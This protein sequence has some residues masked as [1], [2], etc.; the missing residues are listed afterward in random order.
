MCGIVEAQ[1]WS[2]V[3]AVEYWS[4]RGQF[5]GHYQGQ[6]MW[7]GRCSHYPLT[8]RSIPGAHTAHRHQPQRHHLRSSVAPA[9]AYSLH[10]RLNSR[11]P[12]L[13]DASH[14][15]GIALQWAAFVVN[16]QTS[17]RHGKQRQHHRPNKARLWCRLSR[18]RTTSD[19]D[20]KLL[21][22]LRA[23]KEKGYHWGKEHNLV[24]IIRRA[25]TIYCL[26]NPL[27]TGASIH[28][29]Y[30]MITVTRTVSFSIREQHLSFPETPQF[31]E[32]G[33]WV[34]CSSCRAQCCFVFVN[35]LRT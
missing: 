19:S 22:L 3:K 5:L 9:K 18:S 15:R 14:H 31:S 10:S 24:L 13:Q 23:S 16:E 32:K 8:S 11:V 25:I 7:S 1:R 29:S 28:H 2:Q 27:N 34:S 6:G 12:F 4:G 26:Y 17:I 21:S 20:L 35:L 30:I 33:T